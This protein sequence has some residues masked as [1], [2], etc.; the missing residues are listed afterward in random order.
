MKT[1]I[2]LSFLLLANYGFGQSNSDTSNFGKVYF[3]RSTGFMA[4]AVSFK[5]SIDGEQICKLKNNRYTLHNIKSGE[6]N[7]SVDFSLAGSKVGFET[8][9]LNI[10]PNK[11]YYIN[12]IMENKAFS[13]N[14]YCEETTESSAL[15]KI[16]SLKENESCN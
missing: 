10:E 1:L 14:I 16:N 5:V 12:I 2:Y 15:K 9:K 6:H 7:F 11:T 4:S 13:Y 3:I 8:L